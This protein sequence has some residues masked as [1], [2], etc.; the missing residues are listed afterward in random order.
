MRCGCA[1]AERG[2]LVCAQKSNSE[3]D[4]S[5]ITAPRTRNCTATCAAFQSCLPPPSLL[6]RPCI[7]LPLLS[8]VRLCCCCRLH[9]T[10]EPRRGSSSSSRAHRKA[11]GR[12]RGAGQRGVR[13]I[14]RRLSLPL[15]PCGGH[16]GGRQSLSACSVDAAAQGRGC[17]SDLRK[18]S[19]QH[20]GEGVCI[21]A[22][23][24][25]PVLLSS[26]RGLDWTRGGNGTQARLQH[27]VGGELT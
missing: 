1:D 9:Q 19:S 22:P 15:M 24:S 27:A 8:S 17:F 5:A 16:S 10:V 7:C 13:A 18:V 11:Q 23:G 2:R 26:N 20:C 21:A 12:R 4:V 3:P 6:L 14:V 25:S